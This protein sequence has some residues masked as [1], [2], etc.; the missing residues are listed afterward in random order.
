MN[1]YRHRF[2]DGTEFA[3]APGKQVCVGRNYAEHAKELGNDIPDTPLLFMKPATAMVAMAE[4]LQLPVG[5]G[6]CHHELELALLIGQSL[7]HAS[8]DKCLA[9]IAGIVLALD[10]TL[11]DVKAI[12]K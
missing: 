11:H 5:D 9:A 4:P 12:L 2:I 6:S 8:P 1:L 7:S 10:Q 3:A